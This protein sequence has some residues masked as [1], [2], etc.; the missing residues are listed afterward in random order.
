MITQ[1]TFQKISPIYYARIIIFLNFEIQHFFYEG[2]N[3]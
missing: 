3:H 1:V 2:K